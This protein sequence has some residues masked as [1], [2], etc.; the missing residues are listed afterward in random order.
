MKELL[1]HSKTARKK[2]DNIDAE[3][4]GRMTSTASGA[5]SSISSGMRRVPGS[6]SVQKIQKSTA[7][8]LKRHDEMGHGGLPYPWEWEIC[9]KLGSKVAA[10]V[11]SIQ[12][13]LHNYLSFKPS[14]DEKVPPPAFFYRTVED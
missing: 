13:R 14:L 2:V 4:K 9:R 3:E 11:N 6:S 10:P 12:D 7:Q 1:K 5:I 8:R